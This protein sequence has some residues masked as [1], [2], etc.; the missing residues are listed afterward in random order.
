MGYSRQDNWSG[1][2]CPPPGGLPN[3][4]IE[5]TSPEA[6]ALHC[7]ALLWKVPV[8]SYC[9]LISLCVGVLILLC[10]LH[11]G[12]CL[13]LTSSILLN[14]LFIYLVA[15]GHSCYTGSSLCHVGSFVE[16]HGPSS[17]GLQALEHVGS[18]TTG[19]GLSNC[20]A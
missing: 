8:R 3:S 2:P 5:P 12:S 15:L 19:P 10:S 11:G 13:L 4:G 17:C 9:S 7:T 14:Q 20:R 16:A 6:P 18:V 1:L